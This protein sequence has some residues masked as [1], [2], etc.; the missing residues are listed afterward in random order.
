MKFEWINFKFKKNKKFKNLKI[1]ILITELKK[2]SNEISKYIIWSSPF[3]KFNNK[4]YVNQ[5]APS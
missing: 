1:N 2:L 5:K 4:K 3:F